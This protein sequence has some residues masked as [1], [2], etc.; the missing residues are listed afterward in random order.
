[1]IWKLISQATLKLDNCIDDVYTING[2]Y[3][4]LKFMDDK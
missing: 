3:V 1:M 4:S 2:W